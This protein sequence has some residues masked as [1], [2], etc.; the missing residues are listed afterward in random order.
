MRKFILI[1]LIF[2]FTP[3][4]FHARENN[5]KPGVVINKENCKKYLQ[6]LKSLMI[7]ADFKIVKNGLEN[8]WIT[9]PVV[10]KKK[11][12][13]PKQYG[14]STAKYNSKCRIGQRNELMGWVAGLPFLNPK[15]GIELAWNVQR[16]GQTTDQMSFYGNEDYH[17]KKGME[18]GDAERHIRFHLYNLYYLG[19]HTVPPIPEISGNDDLIRLKESIL[20][21][22]PFDVKGFT[23]IRIS[24]DSI[25]KLDDVFSYVPAIR[26]LRRL[27]GSDVTDPMLG[28][29]NTY[30]DFEV[31]RQ[32]IN[33]KMTFNISGI[34][35][36]LVP[37]HYT[38]KP[39]KPFVKHNCYQ[40]EWE[41]RPLWILKYNINDP[42][43]AYSKRIIYVEK[44]IPNADLYGGECYDQKG[45]FWRSCGMI[46]V[47]KDP[48]T[49]DGNCWYGCLF[50]DHMSSHSTLLDM[51][52]IFADPKATPKAFTIRHLLKESR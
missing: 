29:D 39:P 5:I 28:G 34:R 33:P 8:G 44:E 7:P 11:Y 41:I 35:N 4:L 3:A 32:K 13:I 38:E 30:D 15:N 49:F 26:R 20:M 52:P 46:S 2:I 25:D 45:R 19:R 22:E 47:A 1:L 12:P 40:M 9:V 14:L 27:T 6:E 31:I 42:S 17:S 21:L 36:F 10:E 18:T 37:R 23:M 50:M 48:K 51:D 24:Y 43:Y 16:R